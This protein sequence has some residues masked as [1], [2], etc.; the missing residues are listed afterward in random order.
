M[1]RRGFAKRL[2]SL[3]LG[4]ILAA[5]PVGSAL[6][7]LLD[8]LRRKYQSTGFLRVAPLDSLPEGEPTKHRI[9]ADRD[10]AWNHYENEP[11]GAVYVIRNGGDVTAFQVICPHAGCFVDFDKSVQRF[12]CP[13]HASTFKLDGSRDLAL[14]PNTPAARGLDALDVEVRDR[15]VYVRYQKFEGLIKEKKPIT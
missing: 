9:I 2:V 8:P 13:C 4:F 6:A 10:D 11:I 12:K 7:F 14:N 3:V 1:E 5:V 15:D